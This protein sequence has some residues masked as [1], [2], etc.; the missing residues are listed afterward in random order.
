VTVT[1][2]VCPKCG[3]DITVWSGGIATCTGDVGSRLVPGSSPGEFVTED[4]VPCGWR[5]QY[6]KRIEV[7]ELKTHHGSKSE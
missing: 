3:A 5:G 1:K 4:L 7:L 2:A 6:P